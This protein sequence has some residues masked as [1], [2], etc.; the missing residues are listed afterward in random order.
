M[1]EVAFQLD[2]DS[3]PSDAPA[4]LNL[5]PTQG[6]SQDEPPEQQDR[7]VAS[8]G[9]EGAVPDGPR[10]VHVNL[11]PYFVGSEE[12][13]AGSPEER[14]AA[15]P[16]SRRPGASEQHGSVAEVL[17]VEALHDLVRQLL[18]QHPHRVEGVGPVPDHHVD[19]GCWASEAGEVHCVPDQIL[20]SG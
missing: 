19:V 17:A 7:S 16:D 5:L 4:H 15:A 10:V 8:A 20:D 3:D 2:A 11:D 9:D 14:S 1:Y 18:V 6:R 12:S 13:R